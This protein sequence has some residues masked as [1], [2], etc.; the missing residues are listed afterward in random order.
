MSNTAKSLIWASIILGT[1]VLANAQGLSDAAS[2]GLIAGLSG[3][4]I[5]SLSQSR[6]CNRAC[7]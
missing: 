3:A 4:A 5:G 1:A 2:F 6:H 7:A